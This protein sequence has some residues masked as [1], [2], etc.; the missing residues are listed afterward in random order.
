M[1][2]V[3]VESHDAL[4]AARRPNV[5]SAVVMTMGALHEGHATLIRE[6]RALVGE[7]GC[8]I[9]TD[10]VNPTQFGAGEDFE[11][12]P[13]SLEADVQLSG[14]AGADLVYA[15]TVTEIYGDASFITVDPGPLG[16]IL[17]GAARPGHFR[18]MLTV[19]AK[20]LHLTASDSALF[21]EKDYQQLVLITEMVRQLN[22]PT[23]V[24]AVE[25]VREPDGLAMSSRNRY[26]STQER[27]LASVVPSALAQTVQMANDQGA[28][29]GVNAGLAV[30]AA[31]PGVAV[32]YLTVTDPMLGAA[33]PGPGR[34]LIAVRV[35]QTRL[36]DNLP[37]T[38]AG[39]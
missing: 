2:A 12:Y 20:L 30:L 15:P 21:G 5:P 18:G 14:A 4:A 1:S 17:E 34:A 23:K 26:L 25:T 7:T 13:R 16:D 39:P 28:A 8:V 33:K 19:V 32:D 24:V 38:V 9:V 36:L 29:A 27:A 37:C 6:A 10:F 11:R 31:I 35:G 22:F 3:L